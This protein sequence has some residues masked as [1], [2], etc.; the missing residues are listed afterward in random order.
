LKSTDK[1]IENIGKKGLIALG[2]SFLSLLFTLPIGESL[3]G[4]EINIQLWASLAS[5]FCFIY[6][7]YWI[8]LEVR[9]FY[10]AKT[11]KYEVFI[12][13]DTARF[14]PEIKIENKEPVKIQ[15]IYIE[16]IRFSWSKST[17]NDI[18]K[19]NVGD[20]FFSVGLPSD[21]SIARSPVYVKIAEAV[22]GSNLTCIFTDNHTLHM[23]L[24]KKLSEYSRS[25]EYE[26][27]L[28][29]TGK[30]EDTMESV[31]FGDYH[32]V[33]KHEQIQPH[34]EWAGQDLFTWTFFE[35]TGEQK[36]PTFMIELENS[37]YLQTKAAQ[38]SVQRTT[39]SLRVFWQFPTPWQNSIFEHC[40]RPA[41]L[42]L[43]QT[44]GRW[45]NRMGNSLEGQ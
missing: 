19:F 23:P 12:T 42:P 15:D 18:D 6:F 30:F 34:G 10:L 37:P 36:E 21:R 3:F 4:Q 41:Q 1:T 8:Y 44:V 25:A 20:R 16:M 7:L 9:R 11:M 17:W 31:S 5:A 38:H 43:T 13:G 14:F 27:V 22:K 28:R 26:F 33:L 24:N 32:A 40:A 35:K 39:G 2:L 29:V 45:L